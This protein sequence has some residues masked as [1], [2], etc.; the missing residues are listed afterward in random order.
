VTH[1]NPIKEAAGAV[2]YATGYMQ[3]AVEGARVNPTLEN[4][5]H[6]KAAVAAHRAAVDRLEAM[7][8]AAAYVLGQVAI[9]PYKAEI[10]ASDIELYGRRLSV[11]EVAA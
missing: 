10:V 3:S 9:A 1:K 4:K 2:A 11:V 7:L 5:R 6:A 8:A